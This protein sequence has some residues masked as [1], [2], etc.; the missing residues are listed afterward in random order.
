MQFHKYRAGS[1]PDPFYRRAQTCPPWTA[2]RL[3]GALPVAPIATESPAD[4]QQLDTLLCILVTTD[5]LLYASTSEFHIKSCKQRQI[6]MSQL[7]LATS[8]A[9][10]QRLLNGGGS[11]QLG[12]MSKFQP[13][14]IYMVASH[15]ARYYHCS[16]A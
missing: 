12:L 9:W 4:K 1:G 2:T 10:S 15:F 7:E 13:S 6:L 8:H 16:Q 5:F 3:E 14:C 11:I